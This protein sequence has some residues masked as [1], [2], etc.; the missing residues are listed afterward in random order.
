MDK[1]CLS[2]SVE[3]QCCKWLYLDTWF[4]KD[5]LLKDCNGYAN[6]T[7]CPWFKRYH[8]DLAGNDKLLK[9]FRERLRR[10]LNNDE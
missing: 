7:Q 1:K 9:K 2:F 5:D 3:N 10:Q 8:L 4:S 6:E